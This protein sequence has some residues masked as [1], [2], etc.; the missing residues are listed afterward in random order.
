MLKNL[1]R[2]STSIAAAMVIMAPAAQA[3]PANANSDLNNL[4]DD[5]KTELLLRNFYFNRSHN[6]NKD[7]DRSWSQAGWLRFQSGYVGGDIGFG[8]DVGAFGAFK[9]NGSNDNSGNLPLGNSGKPE[10]DFSRA[11]LTFKMRWSHSELRAG[12]LELNTPAIAGDDGR[13][14]PQTFEGVLI[15]YNEFNQVKLTGGHLRKTAFRNDGGRT[16]IDK[17]MT[18]IGADYTWNDNWSF[19]YWFNRWTDTYD[20]H[21]VGTKFTHQL[22]ARTQLFGNASIYSTKDN[23][24]GPDLDNK[25]YGVRVGVARDSHKASVGVQKMSGDNG[26]AFLPSGT[27]SPYLVN[28]TTA[29]GAA[30]G[31]KDETSV[32]LRYDFDFKEVGIPGM[33][34][35]ARYTRGTEGDNSEWGRDIDLGYT[36]QQ[37]QF[38][39]L[40]VKLRTSAVRAGNFGGADYDEFRLIT[41]YPFNF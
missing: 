33:N 26:F 35:M 15:N 1:T 29:G 7:T 37:G 22:D 41:V 20:Q 12:Q 3:A 14:L 6:D 5:S 21:Y 30:F 38:K 28:W 10:S 24:D 36:F 39:D 23:G 13:V 25:A 40:S 18:I 11:M 9:I 16:K 32:Q 2:L 34:V 19:D 31:N 4:I 8:V 17:G 27:P